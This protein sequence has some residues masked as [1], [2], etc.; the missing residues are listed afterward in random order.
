MTVYEIA[1]ICLVIILICVLLLSFILQY[2]EN[3]KIK[4]HTEK[5]SKYDDLLFEE[6]IEKGIHKEYKPVEKKKKWWQE[7]FSID[8]LFL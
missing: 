1:I 4:K 8:N 3:K 7:I 6:T 2:I 5:Y